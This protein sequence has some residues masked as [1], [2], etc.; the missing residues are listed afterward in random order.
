M[1]TQ[2]QQDK[3]GNKYEVKPQYEE[4]SK[5]SINWKLKS[6]LYTTHIQSAGGNHRSV[7][8]RARQPITVNSRHNVAPNQQ[9]SISSNLLFSFRKIQQQQLNTNR[10]K[11]FKT[12][13]SNLSKRRRSNH[14]QTTALAQ[15]KQLRADNS[16]LYKAIYLLV[17]RKHSKRR[18]IY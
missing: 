5:Q 2:T 14:Q 11:T 1:G 4:L 18:R 17:A 16:S 10:T 7:I 13:P 6:R 8:I 3:A 9:K 12:T 15:A